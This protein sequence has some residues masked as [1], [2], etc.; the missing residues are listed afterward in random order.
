MSNLVIHRAEDD[1][2]TG[3]RPIPVVLSIFL[4]ALALHLIVSRPMINRVEQLSMEVATARQ[5]LAAVAGSK[6]DAWRTNDLLTALTIQ[7]ERVADAEAALSRIE[8]MAATVD[9]LDARIAAVAEKTDETFGVVDR[10]DTLHDRLLTAA[11]TAEAARRDLDDIASMSD[12]VSELAN[13][14]PLHEQTLGDLHLRVGELSHLVNDL[15]AHE[16]AI[17]RAEGRIDTVVAMS[18]RLTRTDTEAAATSAD[19]LI[20]VAE[21]LATA[22]PAMVAPANE[23]LAGLK[24]ATAGLDGQSG[25]LQML[26]DSGNVIRDFEAE[27][28]AHI[29]GLEGV[30]GK[31]IEFAM[32]EPTVGR[33]AGML[34]PLSEIASLHT[35][36][37]GDLQVVLDEMRGQAGETAPV[38]EP[39]IEMIA[40]TPAGVV[41]RPKKA[42][43]ER[44]TRGPVRTADRP[45]P[46]PTPLFLR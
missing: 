35:A 10:F 12:R 43:A 29:R 5:E 6:T 17:K 45:V 39:L 37:P 31:M 33:V 44:P 11:G 2:P 8:A 27:L 23:V 40:E 13:V 21:G 15:I 46:Q 14:A 20:A 36:R 1:A 22:G 24:T 30:R 34:R 9:T 18:E 41:T 28:A 42:A 38:E 4:T 32:L 16:D 26:I 7:A 3:M 25:R 19:G